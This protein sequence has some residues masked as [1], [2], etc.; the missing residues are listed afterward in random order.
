VGPDATE[1]GSLTEPRE[2]NLMF[3]TFVGATSGEDNVAY[4]RPE[5]A[6]GIFLNYKNVLDT[7]RVK[8]PFGIAQVG[9]SF[10]NEV[11]PRNF[12][13]RSREFEQMEMEFFCSPDS[14]ETWFEYWTQQ[15]LNWWKS[16]GVRDENLILR[17]HGDDEL[18]HY[19][20]DGFGT[21]DIEYAYPFSEGF[22]ELEGVAHRGNFDL[23]QHQEHSGTKMEFF[24]PQTR[25]RFVPHVIEPASGLTRG[26]LVLLIEAYDVDENRP[27][28]ELMRF[29]PSLA[30]I[31]AGIFP[32]TRK[33]GLPE[34]AH[35]LYMD[36][37][38]HH[39]CQ[40]DEKQS[41]GKRYARMDEAGTPW[42]F[43]ID[44]DTLSD[45]SV[46]VR[47]RDTGEQSR[48]AIDQVRRFIDDGIAQD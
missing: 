48:I 18:A 44:H 20:K 28:P 30:P 7:S 9:K 4:L 27:S 11:T 37:R 47:D 31:K 39:I 32:L 2:F 10:R 25:E 43:T 13:F 5:T 14:A 36:L 19:S 1:P 35:K 17:K 21:Y 46:T 16:L 45:Q 24:D 42:C 3:K 29:N 40:L 26:V 22:G 38:K 12:I 33:D 23:S 8:M 41:I 6:Q 15:R 34:V